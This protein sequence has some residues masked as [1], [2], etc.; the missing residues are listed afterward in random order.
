MRWHIALLVLLLLVPL[1]AEY[2]ASPSSVYPQLGYDSKHTG[3]APWNGSQTNNT[4]WVMRLP[5]ANRVQGIAV[6][7]NG[8][9]YAYV[10][11]DFYSINPDRTIKWV[12]K[13]GS[14]ADVVPAIGPDGTVYVWSG[15]MCF[16]AFNPNGTVKWYYE[17]I[18]IDIY[19]WPVGITVGPDGTV[20]FGGLD[21]S[22]GY[23]FFFAFNPDGSLKWYALPQGGSNHHTPAV[24]PSTGVAYFPTQYYVYAFNPDGTL[25]W[26]V[27]VLQNDPSVPAIGP[28]GTLYVGTLNYFYA[29]KPDGTLKWKYS[30]S[31]G[32][33]PAPAIGPDGT[34]YVAF[35]RGYLY[36]FNPDG[37][38]KWSYS[39]LGAGSYP[40]A[41]TTPP[42]VGADGTVYIG[43]N[44]SS[45]GYVY[46]FNPD[47]TVKWKWHDPYGFPTSNLVITPPHSPTGLLIFGDSA[48]YLFAIG[49]T[50]P[51]PQPKPAPPNRVS[52]ALAPDY[53]LWALL[54]VAMC[55]T[56]FA[57]ASRGK[58]VF[59]ISFIASAIAVYYVILKP[60]VSLQTL[61]TQA[62]QL[63]SNALAQIP[64]GPI[65]PAIV[66]IAGVAV[67]LKIL[68][69]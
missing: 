49:D 50:Q 48:G 22:S 36:A 51:Q 44:E 47:G 10:G 45:G 24:D 40:S 29:I 18:G 67:L 2:R 58:V 38:V 8:V 19:G 57:F 59:G 30:V 34:I 14:G 9:I 39:L 43:A 26:K 65:L 11:P 20:Y 55:I 17:P 13:F 63:L 7:A 61:I 42:L 25:K 41:F 4:Y 32:D 23:Y 52:F 56:G 28:D 15:D 5:T 16:Y 68:K 64:L 21:I 53:S 12:K 69:K 66:A 27:S 33:Y 31:N 6:D 1:V 60:F 3:L 37:T 54:L 62:Q 35:E 46:A